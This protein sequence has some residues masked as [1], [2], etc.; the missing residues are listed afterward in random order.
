MKIFN[1]SFYSAI[2]CPILAQK[3]PD[4]MR[5]RVSVIGYRSVHFNRALLHA[6]Y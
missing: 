3:A 5:M 1:K 2:F 4:G 6:S